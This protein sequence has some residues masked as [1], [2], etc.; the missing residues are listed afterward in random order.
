MKKSKYCE[1]ITT[2]CTKE[3]HEKIVELAEKYNTKKGVIMRTLIL[4][5]LQEYEQIQH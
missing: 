4:K 1:R 5:A 2:R 3:L